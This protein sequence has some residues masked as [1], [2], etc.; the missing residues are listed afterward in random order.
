MPAPDLQVSSIYSQS[1]AHF[2]GRSISL[3]QSLSFISL[4]RGRMKP[5]TTLVWLQGPHG[6]FSAAVVEPGSPCTP[7]TPSRRQAG[8]RGTAV[9]DPGG[10]A[11][12]GGREQIQ[13]LHDCFSEGSLNSVEGSLQLIV[14]QAFLRLSWSFLGC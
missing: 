7:S 5:D 6:L 12:L 4:F 10:I 1:S 14:M 2:R 8:G 11:F 3:A 13:C 9:A